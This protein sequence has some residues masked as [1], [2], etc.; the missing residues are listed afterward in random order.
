MKPDYLR[1]E[2]TKAV[3]PEKIDAVLWGPINTTIGQTIGEVV[4]VVRD[5]DFAVGLQTLNTKTCGGKLV[6]EEGT[7]GGRRRPPRRSSARASR[8]SASTRPGTG[9]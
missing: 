9:S 4:G 6:N 3:H 5:A 2:L 1:F 8:P 7:T